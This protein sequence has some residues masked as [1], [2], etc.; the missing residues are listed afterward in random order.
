MPAGALALSQLIDNKND[1]VIPLD[2]LNSL[3]LALIKDAIA[4]YCQTIELL[5]KNTFDAVYVWNCRRNSDVPVIYASKKLNIKSFV[6]V[7]ASD[8][9]KYAIYPNSLH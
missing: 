2:E 8:Q 5:S 9:S 6:Y 3:G 4:L 1:L 7:S